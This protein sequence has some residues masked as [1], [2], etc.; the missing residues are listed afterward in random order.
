M[1]TKDSKAD[2]VEIKPDGLVQVR[3]RTNVSEDGAIISS[4]LK[5]HVLEPGDNTDSE[6]AFVQSITSAVW[7]AEIITAFAAAKAAKEANV[8]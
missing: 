8:T 5:R 6:D 1:L 2:Q 7:T 4:S 3:V